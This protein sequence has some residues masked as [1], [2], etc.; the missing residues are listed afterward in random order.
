MMCNLNN[1]Y[2]I[3]GVV[4]WGDECAR[5]GRPGVYADVRHYLPWIKGT[6]YEYNSKK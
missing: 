1:E 3:P 2:T 4:S 6:I 5:E